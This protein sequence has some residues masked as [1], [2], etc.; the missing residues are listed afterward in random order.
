MEVWFTGHL[1]FSLFS[2]VGAGRNG[3]VGTMTS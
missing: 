3:G 1:L 2:G